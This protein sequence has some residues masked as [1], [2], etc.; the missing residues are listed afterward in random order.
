MK[1][2][3]TLDGH[4]GPVLCVRFDPEGKRIATG[5]RDR[6][7]GV[8]S[9]RGRQERAL[10]GHEGPV[11]VLRFTADDELVSGGADGWVIV[12]S[13]PKGV[14]RLELD[15]HEGPVYT[16][17]LSPDGRLLASGGADETV[18]IWSLDEGELLHRLPVGPRGMA[19]V[20]AADGEHLVTGRRGDTLRFW[21]IE[22]GEPV[23]EQEAG[24]GMVGAFELDRTGDWVVS[25]GWRGPVTVWSLAQWSYAGVL[26][27]IE[28]GLVAATLRPGY[29]QLVC[30][31]ERHVG[32]FDAHGGAL[33]DV[34]DVPSKGVADL[35][36]SPDGRYAVVGAGDKR[37]YL[38]DLEG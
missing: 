21:S 38:Y 23:W 22:R 5:S 34:G 24:P 14:S 1:L 32:V 15:A 7:I 9:L 37:A 11:S 2:R 31:W 4:S 25:R 20:F 33:L 17:A 12:W 3:A 30:A 35:D 29:E 6:T 26:P 18:C 28:D 13:W 16:L 19:M 10:E 27:I 36:V 8:W